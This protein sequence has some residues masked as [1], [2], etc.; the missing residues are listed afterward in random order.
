M[1]RIHSILIALVLLF[2]HQLGAQSIDLQLNT[3][4]N[5][6]QT[7]FCVDIQ[8]QATSGS[9]A[10]ELGASSV[11]LS[12]NPAA[13]A[14]KYYSADQFSSMTNCGAGGSTS[15]W[16]THQF[17]AYSHPGLFNLVLYLNEGAASCPTIL[18]E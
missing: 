12:Y 4:K 15:G 11:L 18:A 17:D 2:G 10:F 9:S 14:F 6:D 13:L 16:A 3:N 8:V 7:T 5:C 1:K